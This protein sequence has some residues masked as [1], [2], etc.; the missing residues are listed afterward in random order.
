MKRL[1]FALLLCGLASLALAQ[2]GRQPPPVVVAKAETRALAPGRWVH[3]EVVAVRRAELAAETG[4]R[5]LW[6]APEGR[7]VAAGEV[8]LRLEDAEAQARLAVAEAELA[9][10]QARLTWLEGEVARLRRLAARDSAA[11][12]QLDEMRA[13]R[14]QA[15]AD[16]R[17]AEGRVQVARLALARHRSVAPFAGVVTAHL[18]RPGEWAPAGEGVLR[19]VDPEALELVAAVPRQSRFHLPVGRRLPAEV[20][21]RAVEAVV[22]AL[23]PE[24]D[25]RSR[26]LTLYATVATGVPGAPA[27]L[28]VPTGT[29]LPRLAVPRDALVLRGG[30]A[31]VFKVGEDGKVVR[32]PVRLGVAEGDWIAV[33][34]PG[35]AAGDAVVV[36]GGERLRPGQAVTVRERPAP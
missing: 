12:T 17:A 21:G 35:L 4:G 26:Q 3:A 11:R 13:Q 36:R 6:L 23:V 31:A 10:V 9:R 28:W 16:R 20:E 22:R 14:D 25:G 34:A 32:V 18:R 27:R 33:E 5:I 1:V 15:Q 30:A 8:V 24:A 2:P 19:L 29:A 7:A